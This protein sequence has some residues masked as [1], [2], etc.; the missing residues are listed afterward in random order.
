MPMLSW[1]CGPENIMSVMPCNCRTKARQTQIMEDTG[2]IISA[3]LFRKTKI[4]LVR[5]LI[6]VQIDK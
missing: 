4:E 6:F 5:F 3:S 1:F 2:I